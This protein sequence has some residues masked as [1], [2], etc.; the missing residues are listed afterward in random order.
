MLNLQLRERRL[1]ASGTQ[2]PN[3]PGAATSPAPGAEPG[4]SDAEQQQK[5]GR[6]A[7]TEYR[8]LM[9]VA[10]DWLNAACEAVEKAHAVV[11]WEDSTWSPV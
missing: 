4:P 10:Q 9:L 11:A 3:R 5:K 8:K 2:Q 6:E 7:L 1:A